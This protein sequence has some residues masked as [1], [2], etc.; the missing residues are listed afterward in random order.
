MLAHLRQQIQVHLS[1]HVQEPESGIC[2]VPHFTPSFSV[3]TMGL[4]C[5]NAA[6]ENPPSGIDS[7]LESC[8][9]VLDKASPRA[10]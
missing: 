2:K 3:M 1:F 4:P 10:G 6:L 7:D 8:E 5:K 9:L